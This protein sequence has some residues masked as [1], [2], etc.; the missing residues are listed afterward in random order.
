M[1]WFRIKVLESRLSDTVTRSP[2]FASLKFS[3][4]IKCVSLQ[5]VMYKCVCMMYDPKHVYYFFAL[6]IS[7]RIMHVHVDSIF[8][9]NQFYGLICD[10]SKKETDSCHPFI[11]IL[12]TYS[13]PSVVGN[14]TRG[15]FMLKCL[16]TSSSLE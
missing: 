16:K 4:I 7:R 12:L 9:S 15:R 14:G 13:V 6:I 10:S 5:S 3:L 11:D 2:D 8:V 1:Q